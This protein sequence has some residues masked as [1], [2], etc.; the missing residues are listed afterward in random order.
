[1]R[2][3][4]ADKPRGCAES[5]CPKDQAHPLGLSAHLVIME[6]FC[7]LCC[8]GH[9]M[10]LV[11]RQEVSLPPTHEFNLAITQCAGDA[12]TNQEDAPKAP[13]ISTRSIP[14]A[15]RRISKGENY[16]LFCLVV[17]RGVRQTSWVLPPIL[18]PAHELPYL[19]AP[20]SHRYTEW[21]DR[22]RLS[23][24]LSPSTW[25]VG[26]SRYNGDIL[27]FVLWWTSSGSRPTPGGLPSTNSRV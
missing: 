1:M 21:M 10:G 16:W 17:G 22:K 7:F 8:G 23:L 9:H 18:S 6:I 26:A 11:R 20:A 13:V 5:A 15:C 4:C 12:P 19:D 27:F 24:G 3:R 2:R 14:L 25:L